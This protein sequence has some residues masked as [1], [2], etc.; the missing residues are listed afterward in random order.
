MLLRY[1]NSL[2]HQIFPYFSVT[3]DHVSQ[4][5]FA[6]RQFVPLV[7][8][9][10]NLCFHSIGVIHKRPGT[11]V[12]YVK[13][14]IFHI[15]YRKMVSVIFF[16]TA[17]ITLDFLFSLRSNLVYLSYKNERLVKYVGPFPLTIWPPP[18]LKCRLYDG[19]K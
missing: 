4:T 7:Y 1:H 18:R 12:L 3:C 13:Y 14:F 19:D 10:K 9:Q 16:I 11:S 5:K 17:G 8:L 6:I 2:L 15:C